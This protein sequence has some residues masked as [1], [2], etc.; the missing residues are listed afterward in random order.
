MAGAV[1]AV[2]RAGLLRCPTFLELRH[3]TVPLLYAQRGFV[4]HPAVRKSD[5]NDR[6]VVCSCRGRRQNLS[7]CRV[8]QPSSIGL[9]RDDLARLQ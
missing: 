4:G 2:S 6:L 7:H 5:Q 8:P 3:K 9:P 1:G